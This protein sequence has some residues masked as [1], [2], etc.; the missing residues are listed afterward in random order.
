ME[1]AIV[2][3][4]VTSLDSLRIALYDGSSGQV[5]Y[6]GSPSE[7]K[8]FYDAESSLAF[9]VWDISGIQDG[10]PDGIVLYQNDGDVIEFLSYEGTFTASDGVAES[11]LSTDIGYSENGMANDE[12]S[13]QRVGVGASD[14]VNGRRWLLARNTRGAKN[15]FQ[16]FAECISVSRGIMLCLFGYAT[17]LNVDSLLSRLLA[18]NRSS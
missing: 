3:E 15:S 7:A 16:T 12:I 13:L 4:T 10:G 9:L 18:Q 8:R 14:I 11:L 1:V 5:Y 17:Q 2:D 6:T